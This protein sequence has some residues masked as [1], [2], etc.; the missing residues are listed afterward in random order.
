MTSKE[1]RRDSHYRIIVNII[2]TVFLILGTGLLIEHYA[3]VD[4]AW[5]HKLA[6]LLDKSPVKATL[7]LITILYVL[8]MV[9]FLLLVTRSSE[10]LPQEEAEEFHDGK[11]A[12]VQAGR[13]P[14]ARYHAGL[15]GA[16]NSR[17]SIRD[18]EKSNV[19]E[20]CRLREVF[21]EEAEG[22]CVNCLRAESKCDCVPCDSCE[23]LIAKGRFI[24]HP[25]HMVVARGL[26]ALPSG[27]AQLLCSSCFNEKFAI[28]VREGM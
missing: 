5:M 8:M 25:K 12:P 15:K 13:S 7:V 23:T 21:E 3:T 27:G 26:L 17:G 6:D 11:P 28:S 24:G 10:D 2:I 19:I 16:T 9:A 18:H 1:H 4:T 20:A 22:I 14:E